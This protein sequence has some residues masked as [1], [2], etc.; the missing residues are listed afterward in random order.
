MVEDITVDMGKPLN[1]KNLKSM[2]IIDKVRIKP[3]LDASWETLKDQR[4]IPN[5]LYLFSKIDPPELPKQSPNFM[6]RKRE[7]SEKKKKKKTLKLGD[8][9]AS[10]KKHVPLSS[11]ALNV[12]ERLEVRL[13]QEAE[14]RARKEVEEKAKIEAGERVIAVAEAEAKAKIDAEEAARIA[15]EEAAKTLEVALT[16]SESS[17]SDLFPLVLMT[18]QELQKEQ[19]LVRS[20][21]DQQDQVNSNIQRLISQLLQRMPPPP[22]P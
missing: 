8:S 20:K 6:K 17:I 1:A 14:E 19:Q 2:G 7:H 4:K 13:A 11:S 16:Q 18:L 5:G 12:E 3:T 22:I 15:A 10:Q 21:L 9:S